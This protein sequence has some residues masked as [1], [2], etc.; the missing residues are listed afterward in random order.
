[1]DKPHN[2]YWVESLLVRQE[3]SR[4]QMREY[5]IWMNLGLSY[6][7]QKQSILSSK[8]FCIGKP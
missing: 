1:M 7:V 2:F 6:E 4:L 3:E 8:L 5:E